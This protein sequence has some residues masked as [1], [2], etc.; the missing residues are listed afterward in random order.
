MKLKS[1]NR[2]STS[3][4]PRALVRFL[5]TKRHWAG[6]LTSLRAA[7]MQEASQKL[8]LLIFVPA[9]VVQVVPLLFRTQLTR[10]I[11]EV[12][13]NGAQLLAIIVVILAVID[14]GLFAAAMARF[15]RS[16]MYLD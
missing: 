4:C 6:V 8:L 16:R 14:A 5:W 1:P 7:T 15:Q 9:I 10:W 11:K 3:N 13:V 2:K 12:E